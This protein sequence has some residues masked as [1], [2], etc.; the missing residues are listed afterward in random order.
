MTVPSASQKLPIS[1][2]CPVRNCRVA[3][4]E[5][6]AH[7]R[8]LAPLVKEIL[9]VDSQSTDGTAE[10]LRE[11][12]TGIG[13]R[14]LDHPPGLYPS[15]NY[16]IS[17][18][19]QPYL[20]VATVGDPLPAS[21]LVRLHET[22]EKFHA[23]VVIS[24]PSFIGSD[25]QPFDFKWPIHEFL[26]ISG[27]QDAMVIPPKIWML[28]TFFHLPSSLLSSSAGNLYRTGFLQNHPF[29]ST[30]GHAG[31]SMW[32]L[33]MGMKTRWVIDPKVKSYFWLHED[34]ADKERLNVPLVKKI[35]ETSSQNF[36]THHQALLDQGVS[37]QILEEAHLSVDKCTQLTLVKQRYR[38]VRKPFI[39][40][41]FQPEAIR[42]KRE[43]KSII[44]LKKERNKRLKEY[45]RQM[46]KRS[47]PETQTMHL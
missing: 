37:N 26:E 29:P 17:Q 9:V 33:E 35:R 44:L 27:L 8:M 32:A 1:V 24:A 13:A 16:G 14:F 30:Y 46:I 42:L 43:K 23:D 20:T 39:P 31:D 21:S 38:S 12:L 5:H 40:W 10:Y 4:P 2:I 34:A 47:V 19:T 41:F 25:G 3:L 6:A 11:A 18:A 15:W 36:R 22:M 7:L 28:F 45:I